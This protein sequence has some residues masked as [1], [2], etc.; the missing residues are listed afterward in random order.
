[1]RELIN[2]KDSEL[3]ENEINED[4]EMF[5]E[6]GYQESQQRHKEYYQGLHHQ[7]NREKEDGTSRVDLVFYKDSEYIGDIFLGAPESQR[8]TVVIDTGSSWLNIK[9]CINDK[10]CHKHSYEKENKPPKFLKHYRKKILRD[11]TNTHNG[12]VYYANKT[13]TGSEVD[14][15]N[16]NLAYGSADLKGFRT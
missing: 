15:N 2:N 8:A 1:M 5:E 12:V 11:L 3:K 9:A 13:L 16:F 14:K 4:G 7:Q 10:H 6:Q